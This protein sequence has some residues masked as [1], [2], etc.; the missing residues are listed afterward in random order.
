[1]AGSPGHEREFGAVPQTADKENSQEIPRCFSGAASAT[2]K[3][4]IDIIAKPLGKRYVPSAPEFGHVPREV[5]SPE[6]LHQP[7]SEQSCAAHG[8]IAVT[9]KITVNLKGEKN[10]PDPKIQSA[11]LLIMS[12]YIRCTHSAVVGDD[13]LLEESPQDHSEP[14]HSFVISELSPTQELRYEIRGTFNGTGLRASASIKNFEEKS[15]DPV[16]IFPAVDKGMISPSFAHIFDGGYAAGYYGYKWAEALDADAF[17]AFKENGVFDRKTAD[18]FLKMLQSGD[19]ADPMTLYVEFRGKKPTTDALL[20][21][22]GI[23]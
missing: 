2:T 8:Y 17:A 10:H 4:D 1:M 5:R 3:R 15:L 7:N 11:Y 22:D 12:E 20:E 23:K 13:H 9:G 18:K 21:R 6:I 14:F 19:T 16:R